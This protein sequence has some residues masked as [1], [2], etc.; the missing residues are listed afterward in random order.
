MAT[1]LVAVEPGESHRLCPCY[2]AIGRQWTRDVVNG[3]VTLF[4]QKNR[5]A[6]HLPTASAVADT[7]APVSE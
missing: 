5:L 1:A 7:D 2:A 3:R 6:Q 4:K